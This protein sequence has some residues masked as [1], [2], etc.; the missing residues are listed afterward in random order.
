MEN[1]GKAQ[2][3]NGIDCKG[4]Q[5]HFWNSVKDVNGRIGCRKF[6]SCRSNLGILVEGIKNLKEIYRSDANK[7][8]PSALKPAGRLESF[9]CLGHCVAVPTWAT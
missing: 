5:F 4:M 9:K 6:S 2:I 3:M 1:V 7:K 8:T